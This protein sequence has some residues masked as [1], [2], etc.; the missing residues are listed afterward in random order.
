LLLAQEERNVYPESSHWETEAGYAWLRLMVFATLYQ[1]GLKS[2]VG[3]ESLS[4]FFKTIRIDGHVGV[5]PTVLREQITILENLLP[6]FQ[7]ECEN[8]ITKQ[9]RKIVAGLD[10]T[11]FGD[12]MI[13]VLMDLRSGYLLLEEITED[14]CFDTWYA[15][16]TPRL[17]SLGI[18]VSHAISDR[19]KALIKMAVTG[20]SCESGADVFHTQQDASRWLGARLGKRVTQAEKNLVIVQA[21]EDKAVKK[22]D[23]VALLS[24]ETD[25]IIAKQTLEVARQSQ[26]DYHENLQGISDEVHPFSVIDNSINDAEKIVQ[27][28]E[29]RAQAFKLIAEDQGIAD[30]KNTL[31]KLRNQFGALAVSVSFWWCWVNETLLSI[32]VENSELE[33]WLT[34]TLLPVTYWHHKMRQTKSRKTRDKYRKAWESASATFKAHPLSAQLPTSE[35]QRWLLWAESMSRQFQRSSSAVEGRNGCLSQMYHNGRGISGKRL[36]AL[37]V[38]HNYDIKREDGTTAA[39][40]LFNTEFPDLFLWGL[41]RMGELPLPRKS[42]ERKTFNSLRLLDVPC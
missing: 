11:F 23:D 6:Q 10:E 34:T 1:F 30:N 5:S 12:F 17:E 28:L 4:Q 2:G 8:S 22:A 27:R 21:A 26:Q 29:G 9:A 31:K 20:F 41:D 35:I 38:I 24:L 36:K 14:R 7:A 32:G 33:Q 16:T 37:T 18:E 3:A 42:R 40:R 15:K 39:M 25:K 13:L 19:A